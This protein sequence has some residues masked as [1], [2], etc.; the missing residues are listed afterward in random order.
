[1]AEFDNFPIGQTLSATGAEQDEF[2]ANVSVTL[3]P[4]Q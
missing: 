1:M 2:W 4:A 3:C